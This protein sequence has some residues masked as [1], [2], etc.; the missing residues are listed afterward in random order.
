MFRAISDSRVSL[1]SAKPGV[2]R[3]TQPIV[4]RSQLNKPSTISYPFI[5]L[6]F[7]R[8]NCY[9]YYYNITNKLIFVMKNF[10]LS[11]RL[12]LNI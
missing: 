12:G 6:I 2:K 8:V 11:F 4:Y 7:F 3:T 9:Y 10:V 1:R 5:A